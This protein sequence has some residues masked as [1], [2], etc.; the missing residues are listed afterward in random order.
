MSL[1]IT[2]VAVADF[3]GD[4]HP[5][6]AEVDYR[7]KITRLQNGRSACAWLAPI[8]S[9]ND[10][11]RLLLRSQSGRA[12]KTLRTTT[13]SKHL[14]MAQFFARTSCAPP[15]I[16]SPLPIFAGS[17]HSRLRASVQPV[18]TIIV[19]LNWMT[20]S[21]GVL[22]LCWQTHYKAGSSSLETNSRLHFSKLAS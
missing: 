15:G 21:S 19:S 6:I 9:A 14:P 22:M 13:L 7:L 5:D 17:S 8:R 1:Y 10:A 12:E 11:A 2:Q 3:N 16:L 18:H 20:L 4:G